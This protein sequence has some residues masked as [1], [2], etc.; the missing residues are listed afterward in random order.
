MGYE[1]CINQ[2]EQSVSVDSLLDSY[3]AEVAEP[4]CTLDTL[5]GTATDPRF[6]RLG[7]EVEGFETNEFVT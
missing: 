5:L 4:G 1:P 2:F 3:P 7:K 6:T